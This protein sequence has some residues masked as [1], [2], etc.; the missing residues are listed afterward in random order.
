[1][2]TCQQ[3]DLADRWSAAWTLRRAVEPSGRVINVD[4]ESD[5]YA[6]VQDRAATRLFRILSVNGNASGGSEDI[7]P[8]WSSGA[9]PLLRTAACGTALARAGSSA[10][11]A[12]V[13]FK[14]EEPFAQNDPRCSAGCDAWVDQHYLG[15]NR[16]LYFRIRVALKPNEKWQTVSGYAHAQRAGVVPNTDVGW[17]ELAPVHSNFPSRLDYHPLAHAAW[18]YLRL[19]QPELIRTGGINGNPDGDPIGHRAARRAPGRARQPCALA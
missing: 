7:C 11:R 14:L 2:P 4:Y 18:Q 9:D 19:Q 1:M 16:Q 10:E 12:R 6:F 13:Y 5:D 8:V 15:A 3:G 17:I